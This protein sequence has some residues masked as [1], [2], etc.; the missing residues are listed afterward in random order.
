MV[1]CGGMLAFETHLVDIGD[2]EAGQIPSADQCVDGKEA[3]LKET[4]G[5]TGRKVRPICRIYAFP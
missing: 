4:A 3:T 5:A 1:E 2:P